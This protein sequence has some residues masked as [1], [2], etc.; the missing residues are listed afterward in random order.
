MKTSNGTIK[1]RANGRG[2]REA[3]KIA[4]AV[5]V[6]NNQRRIPLFNSPAYIWP[7]PGVR[8]VNNAANHFFLGLDFIFN[9]SSHDAALN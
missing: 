8:I 6:R 9:H 2:M 7:R 4:I 3:N 5:D 1:L